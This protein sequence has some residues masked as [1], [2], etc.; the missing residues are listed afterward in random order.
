MNGEDSPEAHADALAQVIECEKQIGWRDNT[1]RVVLLATDIDFHIAGNG[2]RVE[3]NE[4]RKDVVGPNN[5][6]I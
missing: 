5:S 3:P 1:R 4:K 2:V 6:K